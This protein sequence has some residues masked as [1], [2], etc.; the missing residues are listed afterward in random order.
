MSEPEL[1]SSCQPA[2][3]WEQRLA[4]GLRA[5]IL[6]TAAIHVYFGEYM[7]VLMC[8]IAVPVVLTPPL[9]AQT[10]KAN[11]PIELEL[12]LLW[13][14]VADMTLGRVAMLYEKWVWFDKLLHFGNSV[15]LGT[16]AFL[17]IYALYMT[18]RLRTSTLVQGLLIFL[19][20]LGLGGFWEI[21]EYLADLTFE[22]GA[23]GSPVMAPLDDTMWDLIFDGAGGL[24]GAILGPWYIAWSERSDCRINAFAEL[25]PGDQTTPTPPLPDTRSER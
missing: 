11:V 10:G 7:Y 8:L 24:L 20:T 5:A 9:L 14:I 6:A 25:V 3:R 2:T 16:V 13:W 1:S 21:V 4:W 18:G 23:Q 15:V 17:F 12:T 22:H 19:V